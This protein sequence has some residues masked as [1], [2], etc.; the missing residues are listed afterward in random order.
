[1]V[2]KIKIKLKYSTQQDGEYDEDKVLVKETEISAKGGQHLTFEKF[3]RWNTSLA[4]PT[5]R[6][7]LVRPEDTRPARQL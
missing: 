6:R 2:L 3:T 7:G 5:L 4:T 1:M